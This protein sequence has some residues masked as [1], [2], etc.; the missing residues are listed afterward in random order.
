MANV[1]QKLTGH[2]RA[3][4]QKYNMLSAGDRVAVG[5]SGGKDSLFLLHALSEIARYET[6]SFTLTA[7]TADP[8]FDGTETDFSAVTAFCKA[9]GIPHVIRRTRLAPIVFDEQQ[10][11]NPCSLCARMR[12]GI[13]HN[14]CV[15]L[16]LNKL[17]LGHHQDDAVQTFMMNLLYG[18]KIGCFAP[19]TYLSRKNLTM[20]RP[21]VFCHETEIRRAAAPFP[22]VK[23]AC[24]VDGHTARRDAATLLQ[25]LSADFPDL[26]AK[27]LGAMQRAGLDGWGLAPRTGT[28]K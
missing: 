16:G 12:R 1:G 28:E 9:R 2:V 27:I 8:C 25:T 5:V 23:S 6:F 11:S 10:Q 22:V 20:I 7:I 21:L 17:A 13:L 26:D 18:G 24:P 14:M 4:L 19:K 15:E 3:A